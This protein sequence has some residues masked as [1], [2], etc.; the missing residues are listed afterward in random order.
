VGIGIGLAQTPLTA[1]LLDAVGPRTGLGSA[2]NDA[3]REVGGVVGVAV[4]GSTT[5]AVAGP[6]ATGSTLLDGVRV[7][8]AVG[9]ALLAIAA[10]VT[11][12][13][14]MQASERLASSAA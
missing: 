10:T 1:L 7:A 2:L 9:A 8:A 13:S 11:A 5:V 12:R 14:A 4:L 3:V 6:A